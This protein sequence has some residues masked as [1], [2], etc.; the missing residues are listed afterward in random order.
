MIHSIQYLDLLCSVDVKTSVDSIQLHSRGKCFQM[1]P[2]FDFPIITDNPRSSMSH[3][4]TLIKP[5]NIQLFD[6]LQIIIISIIKLQPNKSVQHHS[7]DVF[8]SF[9]EHRILI[10]ISRYPLSVILF[11]LSLMTYLT[12][13]YFD[14]TNLLNLF[15][16]VICHSELLRTLKYISF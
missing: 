2:P 1:F 11:F 4:F 5:T 10:R 7:L 3:Q 16:I 12:L 8:L 6:D 13:I 9:N 15:L 14:C